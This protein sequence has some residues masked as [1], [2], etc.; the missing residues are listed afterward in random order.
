MNKATKQQ[1]RDKLEEVIE[2]VK[3]LAHAEA[4]EDVPAGYVN[5]PDFET[6]DSTAY[7]VTQEMLKMIDEVTRE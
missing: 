6:L 2:A 3:G 7:R 4:L 1:L 5:K